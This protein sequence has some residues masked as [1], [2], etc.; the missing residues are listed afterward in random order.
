MD[1]IFALASSHGKAGVSVIRISGSASGTVLEF[2]GGNVTPRRATLRQ[3]NTGTEVL[4]EC[5]VLWFPGPGSFTGEDLVELHVH[6]SIATVSAV[7]R[8]LEAQPNFRPAVAGEFTRRALENEKLDLAQVEGLSDLVQAETEA[9]RRQ[10]MRI[11][12]GELGERVK[13]WRQQLVR[14]SALLEATIDFA[15]EEVPVDVLPEV[16]ELLFLTRE[17][18][19]L[20][21]EGS[22]FAERVRTGFEVAILGPP[23]SGKSTLLNAIAGREVAIT[24]EIAGTTRDVIEV[25]TDLDGLPVTFLD[26]AGI[27]E[28]SDEI[29]KEG[30]HRAKKKA[31]EAD[32]RIILV[33]DG[34]DFV[35]PVTSGDIVARPKSDLGVGD[36]SAKTGDGIDGLVKRVTDVLAQRASSAGLATRQRHRLAMENAVERLDMVLGMLGSSSD[37]IDLVA[38]ELRLVVHSLESLVGYVDVEHLLSEVFSSFCIGK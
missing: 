1:T 29:E 8:F 16:H 3:L 36:F 5:L 38:E 9:Q 4:D 32:L 17:Q 35:F 26:T 10:A 7:L 33:E 2:T 21:V 34:S 19:V 24:S 6:G 14:A 28:S 31:K 15:D 18:I 13:V 23:N 11:L 12:S 37:T 20:E 25:R 22:S 30:I 27:R